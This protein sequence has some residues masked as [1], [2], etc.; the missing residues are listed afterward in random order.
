MK[1]DSTKTVI[2]ESILPPETC[3]PMISFDGAPGT[4]KYCHER[5]LLFVKC[6]NV[7]TT[8]CSFLP[9]DGLRI[10]PNKKPIV[11]KNFA[12]FIPQFGHFMLTSN[13]L[14]NSTKF[15]VN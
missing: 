2:F 10:A 4:V 11:L 3:Q 13:T 6:G 8:G 14:E 12:D 5:K 15:V 1:P 9:V 7:D